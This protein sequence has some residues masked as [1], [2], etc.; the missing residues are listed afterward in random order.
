MDKST[1]YLADCNDVWLM[2]ESIMLV[3]SKAIAIIPAK[4]T[5]LDF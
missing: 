5:S 4:S 1:V 2:S 3:L